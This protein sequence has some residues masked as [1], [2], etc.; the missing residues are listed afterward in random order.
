MPTRLAG[1]KDVLPLAALIEP[2]MQARADLRLVAIYARRVDVPVA[3]LQSMM[4][5]VFDLWRLALRNR[6]SDGALTVAGA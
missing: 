3:N 6:F 1:Q 5:G 4:D 2:A